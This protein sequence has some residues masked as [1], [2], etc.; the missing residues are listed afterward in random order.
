M[1]IFLI[2]PLFSASIRKSMFGVTT[3]KNYQFS[4][5]RL[6]ISHMPLYKWES[7]EMKF[8]YEGTCRQSEAKSIYINIDL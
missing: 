5:K 7:R 8:Q 4:N 3:L 2:F 1:G 6:W